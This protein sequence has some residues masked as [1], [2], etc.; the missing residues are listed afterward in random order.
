MKYAVGD[1]VRVVGVTAYEGRLGAVLEEAH[2]PQYLV[3]LDNTNPAITVWLWSDELAK[4]DV[5]VIEGEVH[6]GDWKGDPFVGDVSVVPFIQAY[7]GK[8]IRLTVE[9]LE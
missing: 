8:R 1:R 9:V 3:L 2:G 5:K 6:E 4:V 7:M